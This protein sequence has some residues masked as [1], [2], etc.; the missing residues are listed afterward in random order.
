M[1]KHRK[2]ALWKG[3]MLDIFEHVMI[4][5][6]RAVAPEKFNL[7]PAQTPGITGHRMQ[8]LR[9]KPTRQTCTLLPFP[10]F[11]PALSGLFIT[12]RGPC[13]LPMVTFFIEPER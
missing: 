13:A 8:I 1:C 9:T 10:K 2:D 5:S 3:R 12:S 7:A 11:C 6:C 4:D